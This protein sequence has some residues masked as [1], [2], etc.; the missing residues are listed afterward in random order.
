MNAIEYAPHN[1]LGPARDEGTL[2]SLQHREMSENDFYQSRPQL[3]NLVAPRSSCVHQAALAR[4][5]AR[6]CTKPDLR[7]ARLDVH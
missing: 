4:G 1:A 6:R 2:A 7:V 5:K 3:L